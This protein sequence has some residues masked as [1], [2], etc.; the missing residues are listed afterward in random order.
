MAHTGS[1]FF[2]LSI[3]GRAEGLGGRGQPEPPR[4]RNAA[5]SSHECGREPA[6]RRSLENTGAI[7][8]VSRQV[9]QF[10][11]FSQ[12]AVG[13]DVSSDSPELSGLT[14][15]TDSNSGHKIGIAVGCFSHGS[16]VYLKL[17]AYEGVYFH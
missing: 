14:E 15:L 6:I 9:T 8:S 7:I 2:N 5:V 17:L 4:N 1:K 13:G 3:S 16:R 10:S 12:S 11:Q